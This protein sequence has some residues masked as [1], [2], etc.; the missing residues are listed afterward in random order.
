MGFGKSASK[1]GV[2]RPIC[3]SVCEEAAF[4]IG[5][6][7]RDYRYMWGCLVL[8]LVWGCFAPPYLGSLCSALIKGSAERVVC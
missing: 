6:F 3:F 5:V 2:K 7:G 1:F 8:S 4:T